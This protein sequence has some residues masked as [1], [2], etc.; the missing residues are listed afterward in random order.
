MT[1]VEC[2]HCRAKNLLPRPHSRHNIDYV[3]IMQC[4]SCGRFWNE[5][6]KV[7]QPRQAKL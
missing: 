1:D 7:T 2:P 5:Q 3:Q 4:N 6:V